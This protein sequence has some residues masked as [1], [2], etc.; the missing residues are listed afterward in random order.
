MTQLQ[1]LYYCIIWN[2]INV[3]N[4]NLPLTCLLCVL[5]LLSLIK[6]CVPSALFTIS[7]W[8]HIFCLRLWFECLPVFLIH[9]FSHCKHGQMVVLSRFYLGSICVCGLWILTRHT[10]CHSEG[11]LEVLWKVDSSGEGLCLEKSGVCNAE[12]PA[13]VTLSWEGT[14]SE[15]GTH[16]PHHSPGM[17]EEIQLW[18][19]SGEADKGE[20]QRAT[21]PQTE[22]TAELKS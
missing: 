6:H 10:H 4:V 21:R 17:R 2:C 8:D 3:E 14:L 7:G 20:V 11:R 12:L 15:A 9:P 16:R 19:A 22:L 18:K 13:G 5:F 1:L